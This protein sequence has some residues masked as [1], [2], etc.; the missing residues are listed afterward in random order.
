ML[1]YFAMVDQFRRYCFVPALAAVL[2]AGCSTGANRT[3]SSENSPANANTTPS[4]S[5]NASPSAKTAQPAGETL[6][7][8]AQPLLEPEAKPAALD[9]ATGKA[10]VSE[11]VAPAM[12]PGPKLVLALRE[13]DFGSV[14]QGKSLTHNL[15]VKNA[16]K[17]NLKIE[18]V[19][20]S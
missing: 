7:T 4:I 3:S 9:P 17:A 14:A 16:G 2:M 19:S 13:I 12:G 11:P 18:S 15:V 20:P 10:N 5:Q 8:P 6:L 1:N